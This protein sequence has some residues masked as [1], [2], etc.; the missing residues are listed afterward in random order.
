MT[1]GIQRWIVSLVLV[2]VTIAGTFAVVAS[3]FPGETFVDRLSAAYEVLW[4]NTTRRE[5]TDIMREEPLLFFIPTAG[6]VL[7]SGWLLPRM[8]WGRAVFTYIVFG[9]GAVGGHVFW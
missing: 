6:V 9:L 1:I 7:V 8:Y 2:A 3:Y 4:S 5:F